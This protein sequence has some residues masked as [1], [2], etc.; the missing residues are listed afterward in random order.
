MRTKDFDF[1][2]CKNA[3]Y[4][5]NKKPQLYIHNFN[6]IRTKVI[7][8]V[9][10]LTYRERERQLK[11]EKRGFRFDNIITIEPEPDEDI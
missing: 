2:V 3:Y 1:D 8:N 9:T 4:I 6:N 5:N 7:D 10:I 11:Y